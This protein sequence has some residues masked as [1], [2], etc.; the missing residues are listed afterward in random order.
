MVTEFADVSARDKLLYGGAYWVGVFLALNGSCS[1][2][3]ALLFLAGTANDPVAAADGAAGARWT[4][5]QDDGA[6]FV[7]GGLALALVL[8]GLALHRFGARGLS[9][10][11]AR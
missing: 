10:R 6:L 7:A 1:G 4:E 3:S 9:A 2:A 8:A 11:R 5:P